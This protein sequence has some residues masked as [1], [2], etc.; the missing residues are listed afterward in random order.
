[1]AVSAPP[2]YSY[3]KK[4]NNYLTPTVL[5][6]KGL[7]ILALER[8]LKSLDKF[9]CDVCC[10]NE[11][12]PASYYFKDGLT[13]GLM[14]DWKAYNWCNPPFDKCQKWVQ[15]AYYEQSKGNTSILLIPVRTETAYWHDYILYNP[16]V[17]IFWLRKGYKFI[18]PE[19]EKEMGVFK[20]AL[21]L[22]LFRG[23]K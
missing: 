17:Q 6:Q 4:I 13:N 23:V 18:N 22:V 3:K 14:E 12:V 19:T 20:A 21:A 7:Q 5:I 11:N 1:M 16:N 2:K 10:S 15:K 9:D 8:N